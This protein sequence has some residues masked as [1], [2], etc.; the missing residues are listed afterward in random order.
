MESLDSTGPSSKRSKDESLAEDDLLHL[1]S[2]NLLVRSKRWKSC[3]KSLQ[4]QKR[5]CRLAK[6]PPWQRRQRQQA[7]SQ[8]TPAAAGTQP[9][10]G[11]ATIYTLQRAS[12][13]SAAAGRQHP[14][15]R[16]TQE[17]DP[18]LVPGGTTCRKGL[19]LEQSYTVPDSMNPSVELIDSF[20]L[21]PEQARY[22]NRPLRVGG[23]DPS[24]QPG[25]IQTHKKSLKKAEKWQ[26]DDKPS[27]FA[28]ATAKPANPFPQLDAPAG[29][30]MINR[31]TF[32]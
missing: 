4:L 32:I 9:T 17:P 30:K 25:M 14:T 10:L 24:Y 6:L 16:P 20:A 2:T 27:S 13:Q 18:G 23:R 29:D 1:G 26:G 8:A 28:G 31:Q 15:C 12:D 5:N 21:R 19:L 7:A 11:Y 3:R 22:Q